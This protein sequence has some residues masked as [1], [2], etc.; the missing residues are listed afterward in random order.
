MAVLFARCHVVLAE[1]A[2]DPNRPGSMH[3]A[4]VAVLQ[5]AVVYGRDPYYMEALVWYRS[6]CR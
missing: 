2:L 5:L 1:I 4:T 6:S 3:A